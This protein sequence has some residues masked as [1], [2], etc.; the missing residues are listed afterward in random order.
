MMDTK[1]LKLILE[2]NSIF[3][4]KKLGQNFLIDGHALEKIINASDLS[5]EDTVLEVGAGIGNLTL[6]LAKKAKKVLAIEKDKNLIPLLKEA[7][8]KE[9]NID[10]IN[11]DIL[12][13]KNPLKNYKVVANIPYYITSPIIRKFL[14]EENQ[15]SLLILTIQKE[16]AERI[17][18]NPPKMNLLAVS[19]QSFAKPKIVSHISPSSFY[20]QPKIASS[21]LQIIPYNKASVAFQKDFFL[22]AKIGF[23]HPRKQLIKNLKLFN[24]RK[25]DKIK[26]KLPEI[27]KLIKKRRAETLSIEEWNILTKI[28]NED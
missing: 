14:E 28:I 17:T 16:V 9:K 4:S 5:K 21:I 18:A 6:S 19:V 15:P 27:E 12:F 20:P 7:S 2:K 24:G 11:E 22:L 8:S 25:G 10:V 13:Y 3:L 1:E 23:S 26:R